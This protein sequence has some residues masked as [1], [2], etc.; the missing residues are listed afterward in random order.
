MIFKKQS[1][2]SS[3]IE[4]EEPL[5]RYIFSK[6][7]IRANGSIK[8]QAFMPNPHQKTVSVIRH[9]GCSTICLLK[10]GK[11]IG[12]KSDRRLKAVGSLSAKKVRSIDGLNVESDVS[13]GQ[14]R[15]HANIIGFNNLTDAKIRQT[16]YTLAEKADL[17]HL[18]EE[19]IS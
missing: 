1:V 4:D 9:K 8:G 13:E 6:S 2:L 11:N 17:L 14:H 3:F 19:K 7:H 5:A 18:S 16:A 15:R 10:I 12:T